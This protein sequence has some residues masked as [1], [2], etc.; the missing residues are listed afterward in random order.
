[1]DNREMKNTMTRTIDSGS[2]IWIPILVNIIFIL[3]ACSVYIYNLPVEDITAT[4]KGGGFV[5]RRFS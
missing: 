4:M 2:P 1:M 3:L 5:L